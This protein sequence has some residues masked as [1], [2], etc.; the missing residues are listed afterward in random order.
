MSD[1]ETNRPGLLS[2]EGA[3]DRGWR[4]QGAGGRGGEPAHPGGRW[5]QRCRVIGQMAESLSRACTL[6]HT[7][8]CPRA[9]PRTPS[10]L[11]G[12]AGWSPKAS[13]HNDCVQL[14]AGQGIFFQKNVTSF[15]SFTTIYMSAFINQKCI[16]NRKNH[17]KKTGKQIFWLSVNKGEE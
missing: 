11:G 14:V 8:P 15:L 5:G 10:H 13:V 2:S 1:L 3:G 7:C 9:F 17:N 4:G 12:K 6:A 16:K